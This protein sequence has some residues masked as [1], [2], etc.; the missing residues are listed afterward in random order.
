[1][2]NKPL[3]F[4]QIQ[5]NDKSD[6]TVVDDGDTSIEPSLIRRKCPVHDKAKSNIKKYEGLEDTLHNL[7][8]YSSCGKLRRRENNKMSLG[9]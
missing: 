3:E 4:T 9:E 2:V 8:G 5:V 1:M 7:S 6:S